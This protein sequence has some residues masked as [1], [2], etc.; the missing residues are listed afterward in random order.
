M[1]LSGVWICDMGGS[2]IAYSA[3]LWCGGM[4]TS[5]ALSVDSWR[6]RKGKLDIRVAIITA[7]LVKLEI[8]E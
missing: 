4:S 7:K 6:E 2:R 5:R 3:K 8:H 1:G